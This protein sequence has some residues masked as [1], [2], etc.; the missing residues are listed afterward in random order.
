MSVCYSSFPPH[1]T[2]LL[3]PELL[4][5]VFYLTP[6]SHSDSHAISLLREISPPSVFSCIQIFMPKCHLVA[7]I[8]FYSF[9]FNVTLVTF[10]LFVT[11]WPQN[12]TLFFKYFKTHPFVY[13]PF[14][15][16]PFLRLCP[17]LIGT[18]LFGERPSP[19]P[20]ACASDPP[21][22]PTEMQMSP[23]ALAPTVR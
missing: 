1:T 3:S 5:N 20:S 21:P 18:S 15:P 4:T 23:V 17:Y 16:F 9:L 11:I 10:P 19:W 13:L 2:T 22:P 12:D 6:P 14:L 8:F 7:L